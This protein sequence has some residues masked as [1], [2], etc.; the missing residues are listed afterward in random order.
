MGYSKY[1]KLKQVTKKFGLD[2]HF[3]DIFPPIAP[4]PI[5]SWLAESLEM[6]KKVR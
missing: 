1:K 4:Q 2:A 6:A 3:T 5:G